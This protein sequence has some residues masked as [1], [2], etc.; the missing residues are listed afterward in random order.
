M[1]RRGAHSPGWPYDLPTFRNS[2]LPILTLT[3][4]N[5]HA[6]PLGK[7][8][9]NVWVDAAPGN[10]SYAKTFNAFIAHTDL[11]NPTNSRA[12]VNP[13][14]GNP[15]H[16]LK[17]GPDDAKVKTILSFIENAAATYNGTSIPPAPGASPPP[18]NSAPS[19]AANPFDYAVYQSTIQPILDTADGKGCAAAA[20][21]GAPA[22][23]SGF[24]L[25]PLPGANS[26]DMEANFAAVTSRADLT[27]PD[28]SVIYLQAT[29][30]HAAG[31]SALLTPAEATTLLDWIVAAGNV[32]P[33]PGNGGGGGTQCP[34]PDNFNLGVFGDEIQPVLFGTVDLNNPDETRV[35]TGC[36]RSGCHGPIAR[37]GAVLKTTTGCENLAIRWL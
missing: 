23:Q 9:F 28:L 7:G 29:T 4:A 25:I 11:A 5:C 8:G 19:P 30:R 35:T 20:C 18:A 36:A 34:S 26:P 37:P 15:K 10:C 6:A 31:K 27:K 16:G 3:C 1:E 24:K 2:V 12:Y 17:L 13:S 14:G 22:G 32:A 33:P 21:H